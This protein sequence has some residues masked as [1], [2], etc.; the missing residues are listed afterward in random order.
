MSS[1]LPPWMEPP[2]ANLRTMVRGLLALGLLFGLAFLL[3]RS[4]ANA[5]IFLFLAVVCWGLVLVALF[6]SGVQRFGGTV[7][8]RTGRSE[9]DL[10]A[11]GLLLISLLTPW[12]AA[13][14]TLHWRQIFGWQLPVALLAIAAMAVTYIRPWRRF[15]VGLVVA[16]A[17]LLIA[18]AAWVTFQVSTPTFARSGFPFLPIDLLGDGWYI[19]LLALAVTVD[20]MA[21]R[22]SSDPAAPRAAVVWCF[23]L[24]PGMGVLRLHYPGRGRLWLFAAAFIVFLVQA[25]AVAAE[26]FDYYAS[27][28][29]LPPPRPRG[30][31]LIPLALLLIVWLLSLLDTRKRLEWEALDDESTQK[32]MP[33]RRPTVL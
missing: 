30:A 17:L 5:G 33:G 8:Q 28:G 14:P 20:G 29:G 19:A 32:A 22:G 10:L 4:N 6:A 2:Q 16:A 13:V 31:V 26:E 24:M 12:T 7:L 15:S 25:N 9:R 11:A 27:L 23:A 18:W 3:T 21:A 1:K